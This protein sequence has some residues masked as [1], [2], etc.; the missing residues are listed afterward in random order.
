MKKK[1]NKKLKQIKIPTECY[2]EN[3]KW[4]KLF[5]REFSIHFKNAPDEL[6]FAISFIEDLI[7]DKIRS[8]ADYE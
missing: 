1:Q 2:W 4:K 7:N 5:R 6:E 8:S 3:S